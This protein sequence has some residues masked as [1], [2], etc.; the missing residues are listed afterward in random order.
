M[1][2]LPIS[3]DGPATI[4]GVAV[5]GVAGTPN[6]LTVGGAVLT[7]HDFLLV[8]AIQ[9]ATNGTPPAPAAGVGARTVLAKGN[10]VTWSREIPAGWDQVSLNLLFT[11]QAAG[12]GNVHWS[13]SYKVV[14]FLTGMSLD[15]GFTTL[16]LGG[17]SVPAA[18]ADSKYY[19]PPTT[20]AIATPPQAFGLPPLL[21][22][23]LTRVNDGTD[24][25]A[26]DA[27][28]VS[29]TLSRTS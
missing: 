29:M 19:I 6:K 14:T 23:I 24:T 2:G 28:L 16:D 11:K 7:F 27:G 5:S 10:M 3:V 12:A 13:L 1:T 15:G 22:V 9:M 4:G 25:Y 18:A 26:G 21:E 17:V 8:P 20:Q